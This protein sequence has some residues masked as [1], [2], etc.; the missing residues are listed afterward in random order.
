MKNSLKYLSLITQVGVSIIANVAIF[1]G[2]GL[3]L[4]RQLKT[5]AVFTLV[6]LLLGCISA[7][8]TTYKLIADT[9]R[10]NSERK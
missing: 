5:R 4:D 7:L 2:L 3:Y 6:F 1:T 10:V 8:W 9:E